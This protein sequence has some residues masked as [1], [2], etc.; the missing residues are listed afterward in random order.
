MSSGVLDHLSIEKIMVLPSFPFLIERMNFDSWAQQNAGEW[1]SNG[2][3][4]LLHIGFTQTI[5]SFPTYTRHHIP[6]NGNIIRTKHLPFG[7]TWVAWKT[8]PSMVAFWSFLVMSLNR[9]KLRLGY[10]YSAISDDEI[11]KFGNLTFFLSNIGNPQKF[12]PVSHWLSQSLIGNVFVVSLH[13]N[14][15]CIRSFLPAGL[16][17]TCFWSKD[18]WF[19]FY[20]ERGHLRPKSRPLPFCNKYIYICIFKNTYIYT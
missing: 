4:M 13:R 20:H 8:W 5:R 7:E 19:T 17:L 6:F 3:Q 10:P 14:R 1:N 11:Q 16:R 12:K 2:S 9:E 18:H 15:G